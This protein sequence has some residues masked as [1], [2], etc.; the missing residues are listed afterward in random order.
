MVRIV[1]NGR[2]LAQVQTGV[3]RYARE[4]LLALDNLLT[5]RPDVAQQLRCELAVPAG[6]RIPP[7]QNISIKVLP[8]LQGHVW[9]QVSLG[10]FARDAF[11]VNFSYS[12]P[13]F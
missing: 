1:I 13:V 5:L 9:E 7:L 11:L 8:F 4:T 10:W 12:G 6:A 3:Q 2:F